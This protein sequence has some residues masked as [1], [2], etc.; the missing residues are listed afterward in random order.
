MPEL[1]SRAASETCH[2]KA[3][4]KQEMQNATG[5]KL[6]SLVKEELVKIRPNSVSQP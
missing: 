5:Q 1:K 3:E 6:Q 2:K 4:Q